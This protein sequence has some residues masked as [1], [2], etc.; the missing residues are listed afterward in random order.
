MV[1][2]KSV[3]ICC[4]GIAL[5]GSH[6]TYADNKKLMSIQAAKA[7]GVRALAESAIGLKL[8]SNQSVVDM[9]AAHHEIKSET[10]AKIVGS[11]CDEDVQYD[12]EK[13]IAQVLCKITVG[14]LENV[15]GRRTSYKNLKITRVGFGTSTPE[16]AGPL[17]ALRT[18]QVHAYEQLAKEIVG[19][20]VDSKTTVE[21]FILKSDEI[22][23]RVSAA[24]WGAQLEEYG[25]EKDGD[26]IVKMSIRVTYVEDAIGRKFHGNGKDVITV[27]G[28]GSQ[29]D[30]F[31]PA[32]QSESGSPRTGGAYRETKLN[33]PIVKKSTPQEPVEEANGGGTIVPRQRVTEQ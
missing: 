8:K 15:I 30:S 9:V 16:A 14:D 12:P 26:A 3:L 19:M 13:D 6:V 17:K 7:D 27:T 24:I 1:L 5:F 11:N 29:V 2:K 10:R 31:S 32:Q 25:W 21:N 23:T 20:Q 4:I 28:Q 22:K 18:A 33:I